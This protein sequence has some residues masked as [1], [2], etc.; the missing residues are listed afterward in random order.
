MSILSAQPSL[1]HPDDQ[2]GAAAAG[3]F[4]DAAAQHQRNVQRHL[5]KQSS[6]SGSGG[7]GSPS[8]ESPD[9]YESSEEEEDMNDD[10]ILQ[11][12]L[13]SFQGTGMGKS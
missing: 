11:S 2:D 10:S 1:H 12:M 7:S 4:Q 8:K 9:A 3:R 13:K 5:S 6:G